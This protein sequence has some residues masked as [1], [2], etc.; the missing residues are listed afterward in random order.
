MILIQLVRAAK[1]K[2]IVSLYLLGAAYGDWDYIHTR[3]KCNSEPSLNYRTTRGKVELEQ[4]FTAYIHYI[5]HY[6]IV[7]LEAKSSSHTVDTKCT[8]SGKNCF[9]GSNV[10]MV[11][12]TLRKR[13]QRYIGLLAL[14]YNL[15]NAQSP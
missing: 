5:Q 10:D 8:I 7:E 1:C 14:C 13:N 6:N 2:F 11:Q 9:I 4:I 15:Q 12:K 3:H